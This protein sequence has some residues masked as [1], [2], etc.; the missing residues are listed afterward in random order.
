MPRYWVRDKKR[1]VAAE[2]SDT[3]TSVHDQALS[4]QLYRMKQ[5]GGIPVTAA[6]GSESREWN[7]DA[8]K[9]FLE[10]NDYTI[11][12]KDVDVES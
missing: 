4:W 8:L 3:G 2:L 10:Q 5:E 7:L 11:E 12:R 6:D 1:K 9:Q